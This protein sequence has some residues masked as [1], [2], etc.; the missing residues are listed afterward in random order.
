MG[1]SL[2]SLAY[3]H[4]S[5]MRALY[6]GIPLQIIEPVLCLPL[7]AA[8]GSPRLKMWKL[9]M[10]TAVPWSWLTL[11][12]LPGNA[13]GDGRC[14]V[15]AE[16]GWHMD[17]G[18][19]RTWDPGVTRRSP[20][21]GCEMPNLFRASFEKPRGAQSP[22]AGNADAAP[23]NLDPQHPPL[24]PNGHDPTSTHVGLT[25]QSAAAETAHRAMQERQKQ[26]CR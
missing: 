1:R 2:A 18:V 11:G 14:D 9:D 26:A 8:R 15:M 19:P 23:A 24:P 7:L 21:H 5:C 25:C 3:L 4:V 22:Q 16:R 13:A 10:T 6:K 20:Q 12:R 17:A